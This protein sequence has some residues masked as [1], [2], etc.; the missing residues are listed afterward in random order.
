[1]GAKLEYTRLYKYLDYHIQEHLNH[2]DT[3][4]ILTKSAK[5]TFGK[6][7][8]AFYQLKNMGVNTYRMLYEANV[9][10]IINYASGEWGFGEFKAPRVFQN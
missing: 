7:V 1:M 8:N 5:R 3:E 2:M 9:L 4:Q 6:I 10:S